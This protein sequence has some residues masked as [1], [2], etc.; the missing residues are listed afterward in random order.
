[1]LLTDGPESYRLAQ[2]TAGKGVMP[3]GLTVRAAALAAPPRA[4]RS[5]PRRRPRTPLAGEN[6]W[7][8]ARRTHGRRW[9]GP[10]AAA[11]EKPMAVDPPPRRWFWDGPDLAHGGD[12][13]ARGPGAAFARR[14][15]FGAKRAGLRDVR[16][17]YAGQPGLEPGIAGFGGALPHRVAPLGRGKLPKRA[18]TV[19][20]AAGWS[21]SHA[22]EVAGPPAPT[23]QGWRS[24]AHR[25]EAAPSPI[26]VHPLTPFASGPGWP[27]R[28]R[29]HAKAMAPASTGRQ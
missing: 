22:R 13:R 11:G 12:P 24:A 15:S 16:A 26:Q 9:G 4:T 14:P 7:P 28:R 2:A 17:R 25:S 6:R 8:P 20:Q 19:G 29:N 21:C 5:A 18:E 27:Q 1:V 3:P 10:M 23:D